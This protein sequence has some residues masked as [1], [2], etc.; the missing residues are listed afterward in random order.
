VKAPRK[1]DVQAYLRAGSPSC[2]PSTS[3]PTVFFDFN[4]IPGLVPGI[5]TSASSGPS[6]RLDPGNKCRDDNKGESQMSEWKPGGYNTASP[7]LVV[8]DAAATMAFLKAVF[9]AEPLRIIKRHDGGL[10][11]AEAR[12]G[13]SVVM[14]SDAVDGWPALPAYV[15]VYVEDVDAVYRRALAA[16]AKSVADPVQKDDS[17]KRGGV[18]DPG[19]TT[20]WIATQVGWPKK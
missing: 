4:V 17:D 19:G 2:R 20:W 16:G 7:Y 8:K 3:T 1:I 11:H 5:H 18:E 13:D 15:H 9:D 6:R 12:I 14:F 10:R